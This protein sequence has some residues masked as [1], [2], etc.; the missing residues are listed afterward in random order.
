MSLTL[1]GNICIRQ[2]FELDYCWEQAARSLLPVVDEL[3]LCDADSTDGTRERIEAWAKVEPKITVVNWPWKDPVGDT[4]AWPEW[5]NYA[6]QHLSTDMHI[7]LDADELV[8]EEDYEL[9]RNGRDAKSTLFFQRLNF[10]RDSKHLIPEGHCCG[11]KVLRMA[12]TNMPIPSDYPYGPA[13]DTMA[14]AVTS[15]IR[16]FHYGFLRHREQFFKKARVVQKMWVNSFDPRLEAAE[17]Y[18]GHWSTMPGVT[19]WESNLVDYHG[20]HP[21]VIHQWLRE[22][23]NT[24]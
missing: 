16:V 2:G 12:P 6:R 5:I 1:G 21:S 15:A 18:E 9:I 3:V 7:Q 10:W 24:I 23:G 19:G 22:R 13:A 8:H 17:K 20:S 4:Q 14:Q 11:T